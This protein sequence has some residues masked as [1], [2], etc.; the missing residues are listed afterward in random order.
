MLDKIQKLIDPAGILYDAFN[1]TAKKQ[2]IEII[3]EINQK[4][5]NAEKSG[6]DAS[7]LKVL[8]EK[9]LRKI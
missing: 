6:E 8:R 1:Q 9:A 3:P 4:I 2:L 5:K 7:V